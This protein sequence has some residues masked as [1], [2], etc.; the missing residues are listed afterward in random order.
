MNSYINKM[1]ARSDLAV[2]IKIVYV[3]IAVNTCLTGILYLTSRNNC[4]LDDQTINIYKSYSRQLRGKNSRLR[5]S[6]ILSENSVSL[7]YYCAYFSWIQDGI[8][9]YFKAF[10]FYT[11]LE[12]FIFVRIGFLNCLMGSFP[13]FVD[14]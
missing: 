10:A 2:H 7:F 3:L 1:E 12:S 9:F 6:Y 14:H 4:A 13:F 11:M 8:S 5:R